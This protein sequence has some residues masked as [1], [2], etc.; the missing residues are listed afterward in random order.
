MVEESVTGTPNHAVH[1]IMYTFACFYECLFENYQQAALYLQKARKNRLDVVGMQISTDYVFLKIL[2]TLAQKTA[3]TAP[4]PGV[5]QALKKELGKLAGWAAQC[6]QNFAHKHLLAAAEMA[7]V[8]GQRSQAQDL[9]DEAIEAAQKNGFI[10]H[11]ALAAECAGRFYLEYK[12]TRIAQVYLGQAHYLYAKWGALAKVKQLEE[13]Y[14]A[15]RANMAKTST[16]NMSASNAIHDSPL[17]LPMLDFATVLKATHA[18]S[19]EIVLGNLLKK[20]IHLLM[21]NAGAQY[22]VMLLETE[23]EWRIE[24]EGKVNQAGITVDVLQSQA[25]VPPLRVDSVDGE[26]GD[27]VAGV[28]GVVGVEG[29]APTLPNSLIQYVI[30]SKEPFSLNHASARGRFKQNPYIRQNQVKSVLCAPI[31]HQGRMAGVLYLE[32]NLM[33]AAFTVDRLGI[34]MVFSSQAAISIENARVYENLESTVAQRTAALLESSKALSIAYKAAE[35][36]RQ[37]AESAEQQANQALSDL[38]LTQS[39][40]VQSEK[41]AA[42]GHLVAG[43][44]HELNTPIGNVLVTATLLR[45]RSRDLKASL[46]KGE[47]RKSTVTEFVDDAMMMSTMIDNSCQRAATLINIFKQVAVDQ[48]SEQRRPFNLNSLL[49][50][51]IAA[52]R[53]SLKPGPWLIE[54][55]IP[56]QIDCDSYPGPL[57]QVILNLVNNAWTHAFA[58]RE[59]GVLK[60]SAAMN[61]TTPPP[62]RLREA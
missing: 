30:H 44:A 33:E 15:L 29:P 11:Q 52:L 24:A 25:L 19:G 17:A 21:E 13:K 23:G 58:G 18:I 50:D 4:E 62:T 53:A 22:G 31:L 14:P 32:N 56:T 1:Y 37:H 40:L 5:M 55:E 28:A 39:Q 10:Q 54:I 45:D 48:T 61:S 16:L 51:S 20:L 36:A 57:G 35:A 27:G 8:E 49:E 12:K 3:A 26:A 6:P 47:L 59:A 46:D 34:L 2:I 9:Y 42:L 41:M 38:R 60:I 7:R 43:V